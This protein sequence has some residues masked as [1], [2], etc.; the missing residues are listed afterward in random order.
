MRFAVLGAGPAGLA[1]A[2][3]LTQDGHE[4]AVLERASRVGGQSATTELDGFRLD[5]GPHAYHVR[6]TRVDTLYRDV[7]GPL[8]PPQRIDQQVLLHGKR[9]HYPF[10]FGEG[11]VPKG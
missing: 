2:W 9:F 6:G 11:F 10:R 8:D 4:V 1:A 5:Y 7:L 3:R